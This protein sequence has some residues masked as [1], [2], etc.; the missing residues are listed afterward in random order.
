[1]TLLAPLGL[2]GLLSLVILLIIYIIKPNY[3][4]KFISSTYVWKLSLK[5]QKKRLPVS[6]LRNIL[7]ILCQVFILTAAATILAKPVEVLSHQANYREVIAIIDASASMRA[8]HDSMTRFERAVDQLQSLSD[9]VFNNKGVVSVILA[10]NT[11]SFIAEKYEESDRLF[12]EDELDSLLQND[13]CSYGVSN[14]EGALNLCQTLLDDNPD[15]EVYLYTDTKYSYIPNVDKLNVVDVTE[16][17]E[18]N[19]AILDAYTVLED[20]FYTLYVD[21]ACYGR[22]RDLDV[23]VVVNGANFEDGETTGKTVTF[24][25]TARC[26][27]EQSTRIIFIQED[28]YQEVETEEQRVVY[29]PL[30][31]EEKFFSYKDIYIYIQEEDSFAEDNTFSVFDGNK[32]VLKILYR[33]A[34]PNPFFPAVLQNLRR[35]YANKWD[36]WVTEAKPSD[37]MPEGGYSGY[38]FYFFEHE[39]PLLL[40]KDGVVFLSNR[41]KTPLGANFRVEVPKHWNGK[42]VP[43][44][45]EIESHPLLNYLDPSLFEVSMCTPITFGMEYETVLSCDGG[46][47]ALSYCNEDDQKIAVMS[48]N[49]HY[50][51]L[52][53]TENISILMYNV[54]EYFLPA[55]VAKNSF[56]ID[57]K[58]ALNARGEKLSV[59]REGD[60]DFFLE[61]A[62]FPAT[63]QAS[64]PGA[65][66]LQQ[67]TLGDKAITEKI[68]IKI[69][70]AESNIWAKADALENPYGNVEKEFEFNDLLV[71]IAGAMVLILFLEWWL[72]SRTSI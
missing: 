13:S 52:A 66:I 18:W 19:A 55:T 69:P 16:E 58:I 42:S 14:V 11:P 2:L 30:S 12:L 50:S 22:E 26:S 67:M 57:E 32:E 17:E 4:Q 33:S 39:M 20:N 37:P 31:A 45:A 59:S 71:Y 3:Q 34:L 8:E 5:Y 1:M 48:F 49:V 6:K 38:D 62:E 21:V 63:M 54:F 23:N 7:L 44:E 29:Y 72:Q 43:L 65:Y 25:C 27:L 35:I 28:L 46:T 10:N 40:P 15:A 56:E 36:F 51:N 47:P 70:K 53:I 60:R 61:Y 9:E 41:D 68:Y 64:V 24:S